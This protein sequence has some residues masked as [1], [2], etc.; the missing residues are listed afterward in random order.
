MQ[1][2]ILHKLRD[3]IRQLDTEIMT[4]E[5][6]LGDFKRS[7]TRSF[8]G[9]KFGGMMELSQRGTIVGDFGKQI[10]AVSSVNGTIQSTSY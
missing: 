10:I 4:E 8:M 3:E 1:T 2:D 9:L 5:A 7:T 6:K